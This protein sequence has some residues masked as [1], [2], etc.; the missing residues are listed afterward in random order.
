[1]KNWSF[2]WFNRRHLKLNF[3]LMI[4][5]TIESLA[6]EGSIAATFDKSDVTVHLRVLMYVF[7]V[8][9]RSSCML[10]GSCRLPMS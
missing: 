3:I 4:K 7:T 8:V 2:N 9:S 5:R 6:I 10:G 1:M